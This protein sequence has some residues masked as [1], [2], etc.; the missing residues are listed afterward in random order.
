MDMNESKKHSAGIG[1]LPYAVFL[2]VACVFFRGTLS[3][4]VQSK[5]QFMS[6]VAVVLIPIL[7]C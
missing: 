4:A 6:S 5:L 7:A 2:I 3:S 1:K